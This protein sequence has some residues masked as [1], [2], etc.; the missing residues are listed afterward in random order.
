MVVLQ[1]ENTYI[2]S[3]LHQQAH[4]GFQIDTTDSEQNASNLS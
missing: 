3:D 1:L 4:N 2:Y